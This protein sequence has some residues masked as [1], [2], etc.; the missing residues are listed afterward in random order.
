M[1]ALLIPA[2]VAVVAGALG[3]IIVLWA[4]GRFAPVGGVHAVERV[5]AAHGASRCVE[6]SRLL[7]ELAR[8]GDS[9]AIV[10]DFDAIEM[11]LLE[12]IPDCPPDYK[13]ELV[14]ALD[15]CARACRV[16]ETAKRIMTM[17]NSMLA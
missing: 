10:R 16:V 15:A 11:P 3:A 5:I 13:A 8:R 6:A 4:R 9:A 17:R 14:A 1:R 2:L 12:A 7:R